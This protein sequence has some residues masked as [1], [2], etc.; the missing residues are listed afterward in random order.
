[1]SMIEL[2]NLKKHLISKIEFYQK[3]G[4]KDKVKEYKKE[5]KKIEKEIA[6]QKLELE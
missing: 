5:L 3:I 4:R 6:N 2:E 1:M